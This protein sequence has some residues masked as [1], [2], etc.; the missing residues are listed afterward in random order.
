[1]KFRDLSGIYAA[2]ILITVRIS[3]LEDFLIAFD[4]VGIASILSVE[5]MAALSLNRVINIHNREISTSRDR[6][7][8]FE[9]DRGHFIFEHSRSDRSSGLSNHLLIFFEYFIAHLVGICVVLLINTEASD[10][11]R[12]LT[13][14]HDRIP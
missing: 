13:L 1:M 10:D 9:R 3:D 14:E 4:I 2:S 12:S 11:Q 5:R 6:H 7:R 8:R